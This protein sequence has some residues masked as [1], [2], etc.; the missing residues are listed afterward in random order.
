MIKRF[1]HALS[2]L[3]KHNIYSNTHR[4][5]YA[6]TPHI[7]AHTYLCTEREG[8]GGGRKRMKRTRQQYIKEKKKILSNGE[9]EGGKNQA[10][11]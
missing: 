11:K 5:T 8:E 9:A 7:H 10:G 6:H 2:E 4:P 3:E 1:H